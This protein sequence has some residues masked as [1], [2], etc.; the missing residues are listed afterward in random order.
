MKVILIP[1]PVS[2][3]LIWLG[4]NCVHV[5]SDKQNGHIGVRRSYRVNLEG[6]KQHF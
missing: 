4:G 5:V 3:K 1:T 6:K 2:N